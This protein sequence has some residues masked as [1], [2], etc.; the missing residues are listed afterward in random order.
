MDIMA[1]SV[2][3]SLWTGQYPT[4]GLTGKAAG[5]M[6]LRRLSFLYSSSTLAK[7]AHYAQVVG[8][9]HLINEKSVVLCFFLP[10]AV[11]QFSKTLNNDVFKPKFE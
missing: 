11:T 7:E 9:Q 5:R 10:T 1:T 4:S 6:V 3:V 2:I 8:N